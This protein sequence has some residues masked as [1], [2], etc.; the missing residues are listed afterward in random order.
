MHQDEWKEPDSKGYIPCDSIYMI[1]QKRKT[2]ET[3]KHINICQRTGVGEKLTKNQREILG[4]NKTVLYLDW[5]GSYTAIK[6]YQN[7]KTE[8]DNLYTSDLRIYCISYT[9][10]NNDK[11]NNK[12]RIFVL[13]T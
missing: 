7:V 5:G 9:L 1:F 12:K 6:N 4:S 3:E 8:P 11:N 2:K 13:C 10:I